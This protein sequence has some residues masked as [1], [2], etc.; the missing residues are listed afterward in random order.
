MSHT[1]LFSSYVR[2]NISLSSRRAIVS[3]AHVPGILAHTG[4]GRGTTAGTSS[5]GN[6]AFVD[7]VAVV[8]VMLVP[9]RVLRVAVVRLSV[10]GT[11]AE[12]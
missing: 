7:D 9:L 8:G 2:W 6:A 11:N 12:T 10:G 1:P 4:A 3:Y 5:A